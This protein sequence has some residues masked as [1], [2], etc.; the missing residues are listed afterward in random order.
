M[1]DM[2]ASTGAPAAGRLRTRRGATPTGRSVRITSPTATGLSSAPATSIRGR[3]ARDDRYH[4]S[5]S[6][7]GCGVSS[8]RR[9]PSLDVSGGPIGPALASRPRHL[10]YSRPRPAP[11][12]RLLRRPHQGCAGFRPHS[13][14]LCG[15]WPMVRAYGPLTQV[16][17]LPLCDG[18]SELG[19]PA[20][21]QSRMCYVDLLRGRPTVESR[22]RCMSRPL[23]GAATN[24]HAARTCSAGHRGG[25]RP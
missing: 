15:G 11:G 20:S 5:I 2:P 14:L 7:G 10:L 12:Y 16:E 25:Q 13:L 3:Q 6:L 24:N 23:R 1:P 4:A 21:E 22:S 18:L 9:P 17:N 8:S 19:P